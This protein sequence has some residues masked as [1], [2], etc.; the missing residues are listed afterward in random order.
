MRFHSCRI[1]GL[2]LQWDLSRDNDLQP[3]HERE[4]R[5]R[6]RGSMRTTTGPRFAQIAAELSHNREEEEEEEEEDTRRL[7]KW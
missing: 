4:A 7:K 5:A 6:A 1:Y 2:F 3:Q